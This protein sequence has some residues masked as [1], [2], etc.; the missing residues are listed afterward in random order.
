METKI[1]PMYATLTLPYSKEN[2]YEI[3]EKKIQQ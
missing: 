2:L 3:I 1:A